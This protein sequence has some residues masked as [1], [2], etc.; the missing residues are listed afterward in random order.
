MSQIRISEK[1]SEQLS[2]LSEKRKKD[3]ALITSKKMVNEELINFA[4]K[5]AFKNDNSKTS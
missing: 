1:A 5:K 2:E 3:R 4:H